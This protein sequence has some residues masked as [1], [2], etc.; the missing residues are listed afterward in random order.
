MRRF[1]EVKLG[2]LIVQLQAAD[3]KAM[4]W[5]NKHLHSMKEMERLQSL[6]DKIASETQLL[7]SQKKQAEEHLLTTEENY[8]S[9]IKLLTEHICSQNE[10][11]SSQ[12]EKIE[13]VVVEKDKKIKS[14][15]DRLS[16]YEKKSK[17]F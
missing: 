11:I 3:E 15:V 13:R 14:L 7:L 2:Q 9:Q 17:F 6:Y 1:F 4:E 5:Y 8:K 10:K 12:E 16:L